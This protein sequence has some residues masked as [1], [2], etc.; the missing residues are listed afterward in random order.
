VV[1]ELN[2]DFLE[3][4]VVVEEVLEMQEVQVEREA[5]GVQAEQAL[6]KLLTAYLSHRE[7]RHPL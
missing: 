5:R 1:E 6:L 4:E 7:A 2:K 3:E